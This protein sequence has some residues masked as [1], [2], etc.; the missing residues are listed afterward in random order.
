MHGEYDEQGVR[1]TYRSVVQESPGA[2]SLTRSQNF[3]ASEPQN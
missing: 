1:G 3:R 2:E